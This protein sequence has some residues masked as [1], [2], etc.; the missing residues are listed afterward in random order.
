MLVR[1]WIDW[2]VVAQFY[3][4]ILI[5]FERCDWIWLSRMADGVVSCCSCV[6]VWHSPVVLFSC[7]LL[8]LH[9][10][11]VVTAV[12]A[13]T[14][15]VIGSQ[16]FNKPFSL[17]FHINFLVVSAASKSVASFE[18]VMARFNCGF[19]LIWFAGVDDLIQHSM[20]LMLRCLWD[21]LLRRK[22]G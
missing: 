20:I 3:L 19:G 17:L 2:I 1:R 14:A 11:F 22:M 9:R 13:G 16:N 10:G 18:V 6:L 8:V 21:T 5:R 4:M 7:C 15:F 12:L